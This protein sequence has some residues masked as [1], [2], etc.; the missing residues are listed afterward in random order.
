MGLLFTTEGTRRIKNT[1]NTAFDD[2]ADGLTYI[3][4]F[5][6]TPSDKPTS[7]LT[8]FGQFIKLR[9][10]TPGQLAVALD[11]MPYDQGSG[12]GNQ[13]NGPI[14][15]VNPKPKKN[16]DV[17]RWNYFLAG[18]VGDKTAGIDGTKPFDTV[19][20]PLRNALADALLNQ[21]SNG[22]QLNIIRVSFDHVELDANLPNSGTSKQTAPP[23][24]V[25]FDAPLSDDSG[26]SLGT[27]R[28]ITLFTVRVPQNQPGNDFTGSP[29]ITGQKWKTS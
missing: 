18:V 2:S 29:R 4:S 24:V 19:F 25:I 12:D 9:T 23:S 26:S 5:V 27:V 8:A 7:N 3:R 17:K 22:N 13:G 15:P 28:H 1:L 10:W 6:G 11:L 14:H 16:T 21:D 20:V